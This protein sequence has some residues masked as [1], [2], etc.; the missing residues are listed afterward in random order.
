MIG[1]TGIGATGIGSWP[2][3]DVREAMVTVRDLLTGGE[4][5]GLP[6]LPETPARG[7]GA[8]LLGRAAGM[9]VDLHVD[10][11]PSGWR[12]VDRPGRDAGRTAGLLRQD[13]D[14]AAAAYDGY[15][16]PLKIQLAGPWT[17]AAGLLLPRGERAVVDEGACRDLVDS[18]AEGV[19]LWLAHLERLV[20][21]A[22]LVLQLDEPW[23]PA[24]LEGS[25]PTQSGFGRVRALDAQVVSD[26]LGTVLAAHRGRV[27]VHCCHERAPVP[28]L[29]TVLDRHPAQGDLAIDVTAATPARWESLA[30]TLETGVGL[31]A[32][33]LP[34][35]RGGD[36][37]EAGRSLRASLARAGLELAGLGAGG[38]GSLTVTP[39]CGLAGVPTREAQGVQQA[40]VDAAHELSQEADR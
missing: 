20:P 2:G 33:C 25:L 38:T 1:A 7:P 21:G 5:L 15:T 23:L 36:P 4:G 6:Y 39:T 40:C 37:R 17:L 10:L 11:Q 34:T 3:S 26:G 8:D 32:G 9:L 19:R 31:W 27:A 12:L 24:V 29:R 28:L 18:L 35:E 30:A 22:E 14:E 13:L 16:G